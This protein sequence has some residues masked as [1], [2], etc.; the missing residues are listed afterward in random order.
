MRMK[1]MIIGMA[2][3]AVLTVPAATGVL[4][5]TEGK[6][7]YA[8]DG[9]VLP[10]S[11]EYDAL[12][13]IETPENDPDG[14]LF[15]VTEIASA[16]AAKAKGYDE[17]SGLGFVCDITRKDEEEVKKL[18]CDD[19]SGMDVFASDD[20]GN[21]FLFC[22]PTDVRAEAAEGADMETALEKYAAVYE[23]AAGELSEDFVKANGL[24]EKKISNTDLDM[25]LARIACWDFRDYTLST[26]EFGPAEPGEVDPAPFL[27]RLDGMYLAY[28][29]EEAPA[30]EYCVLNLPKENRR[31]DFFPGE[32]AKNLV[33]EVLTFEDG[34][35]DGEE[36]VTMY[37]AEFPDDETTLSDVMNDW[38]QA[39]VAANGGEFQK[40]R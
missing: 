30:G 32:E 8:N 21:W 23:W 12:V 40:N 10:V 4:A 26:L 14:V 31:F 29:D 3:T 11:E 16:D 5:D 1:N 28:T 36:I 18:L 34:E 6:K 33:R 19:M 38:Y 20:E 15:R 22:H 25:T 13:R 37:R 35:E 27:E 2:L 24:T 39:L 9:F 17:D 7:E